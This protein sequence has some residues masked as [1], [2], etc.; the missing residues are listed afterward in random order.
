VQGF[1]L[2]KSLFVSDTFNIP[3]LFSSITHQDDY[4]ALM[5]DK[6][7]HQ[8]IIRWNAEQQKNYLEYHADDSIDI[9][10]FHQP[11]ASNLVNV[12]S[13][14]YI[15]HMTGPIPPIVYHLSKVELTLNQNVVKFETSGSGTQLEKNVLTY[16]HKAFF[17]HSESFYQLQPICGVF[18]NGGTLSNITALQYAINNAFKKQDIK[19]IGLKKCLDDAGYKNMVVIGSAMTHYSVKKALRLLGLGDDAFIEFAYDKIDSENTQQLLVEKINELRSD[20]YFVL[21]IIGIAGTTES[22]EIDNL[23]SLATVAQQMDIHFHVDAAFGG[24]FILSNAHAAK[25]KGIEKADTIS[26][27]GHKNLYMPI[28]SSMLLCANPELLEASEIN[29]SYQ[30]RKMSVDLGKFTI[31]GTRKFSSFIIGNILQKWGKGGFEEVLDINIKTAQLFANLIQTGNFE[32][33][34][35]PELN[36]VLYRYIP[37]NLTSIAQNATLLDADNEQINQLN[38]QLQQMQFERGISFVSHTKLKKS[39]DKPAQVWLRAVF[40]NPFTTQKDLQEIIQE[41]IEIGQSLTK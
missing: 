39:A 36:I 3:L 13:K 7:H 8:K 4:A 18:T 31:E 40:M 24:A 25:L 5:F 6:I 1:F 21:A 34:K 26:L 30:A 37:Q 11:L 38:E 20:N 28:G 15:G 16:F 35:D 17:N 23:S 10:G 9:E 32:L 22:G 27:C 12:F 14:K 2:I 33:Y 29:S 19:K 41:Q